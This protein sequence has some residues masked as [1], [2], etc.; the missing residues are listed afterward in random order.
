MTDNEIIGGLRLFVNGYYHL[1]DTCNEN[2]KRGSPAIYMCI[3]PAKK[4]RQNDG[5]KP[6]KN[7]RI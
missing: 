5:K 3:F 1:S 2:A 6:K 7:L 4:R